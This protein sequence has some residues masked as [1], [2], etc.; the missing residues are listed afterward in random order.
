MLHF[1]KLFD[2]RRILENMVSNDDLIRAVFEDIPELQEISFS[3]T[4]EYDDNNYSD[5]VN[6]TGV[7]G[8]R[9]DYD[10]EYEEDCEGSDLP[11]IEDMNKVGTIRDLIETVGKEF[12]YHEDHKIDRSY[13]MRHKT[14]RKKEQKDEMKYI[15]SHFMGKKLPE[16]FFVRVNP[17]WALYH[18]HEH[19][20]FKPETEFKIFA[21]EGCMFDALRYAREVIKGPLD[22]KIENFFILNSQPDSADYGDLKKYLEEFKKNAA[23]TA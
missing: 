6:L 19:G 17:K 7:N 16:N 20:R 5:Y 15:L 18:A 4:N 2:I 8:W 1:N 11:K 21:R 23:Q 12:G 3:V 10:N 13:A 14:R 22:E 9:V